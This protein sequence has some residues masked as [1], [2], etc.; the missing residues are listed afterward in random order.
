MGERDPCIQHAGMTKVRP[1]YDQVSNFLS[2]SFPTFVI[3]NPSW[4]IVD[5]YPPPPAGMTDGERD[6]FHQHAGMTDYKG[7]GDNRRGLA[8]GCHPECNEGSVPRLRMSWLSEILRLTQDD[9]YRE[10]LF[11]V[12]PDIYTREFLPSF[13]QVC[14]GNLSWIPFS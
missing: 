13:P 6:T 2:L 1:R 9:K 14:G 10:S 8:P 5:G 12:I 7:G 11:W 4:P 3:G